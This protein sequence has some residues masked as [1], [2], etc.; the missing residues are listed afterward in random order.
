[1]NGNTQTKHIIIEWMWTN[2]YLEYHFIFNS[3]LNK[4]VN[5]WIDLGHLVLNK[6]NKYFYALN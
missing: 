3:I 1:M 2:A 4:I 6:I 5:S